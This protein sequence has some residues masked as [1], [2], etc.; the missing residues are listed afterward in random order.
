VKRRS[1]LYAGRC[2]TLTRP[3]VATLAALVFLIACFTHEVLGHGVACV[4][5]G[6]VV[7]RLTSVYFA[8]RGGGVLADLG[9]PGAN[10]VLAGVSLALLRGRGAIVGGGLALLC[11]CNVFW[12][13]G[14]LVES[15]VAMRSD[16]AYAAHVLG[17]G[18]AP[19]RVLCGVAGIGLGLQACRLLARRHWP[20]RA[21]WLAYGA[22]GTVA[23]G[24]ALCFA[25]PALPALHEAA[26]EG[27]G[28]MAWLLLVRP[29][30]TAHPACARPGP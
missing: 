13:A 25:G 4:A 2:M 16:F 28:A 5:G 30:P 29:A 7:T 26:L 1:I 8:C 14:C 15:A 3:A 10:L 22:A 18:E 23:C 9:G 17:P 21:L 19:A 27:F 20:R 6:G 12:V 11:A 24:V